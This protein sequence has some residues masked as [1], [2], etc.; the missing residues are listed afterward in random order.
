MS[1]NANDSTEIGPD[2]EILDEARIQ[3][4]PFAVTLPKSTIQ[5][6]DGPEL[7]TSSISVVGDNA[8]VGSIVVLKKSVMVWVGWGNIDPY[9]T[10]DAGSLK[11]TGSFGKGEEG[12]VLNIVRFILT[13]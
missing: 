13:N 3:A 4:I 8:V 12:W 5:D 7:K 1:V 10:Q 2:V 6:F 9:Q 11:S